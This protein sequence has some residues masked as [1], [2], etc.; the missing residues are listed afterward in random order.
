M[1]IVGKQT[2]HSNT[3]E[4]YGNIESLSC[5][6]ETNSVIGQLYFKTNPLTKNR[7]DL[8]LL[9]MEVGGRGSWLKKGIQEVQTFIYNINKYRDALWHIYNN[10]ACYIGKFREQILRVLI[11][12]KNL[13]LPVFLILQLYEVMD[14]Q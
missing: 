10:V 1:V 6:P 5:V 3:F 7:S 14:V 2:Y 11:R 8:Q 12:K 13:F 9:Q 4:S